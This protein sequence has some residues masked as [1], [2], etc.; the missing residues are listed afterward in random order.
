MPHEYVE[1]QIHAEPPLIEHLIGT[2]TQLGFEGFWEETGL[3]K[4]YMSAE[5]WDPT[6]ETAIRDI[7]RLFTRPSTEVPPGFSI[8]RIQ[9]E[10]WNA[11]WEQSITPI[12]LTPRIVVSPTWQE[13]TPASGEILIRINPKMS[14]GTGYHESTRLAMAMIENHL[15]PGMSVLDVGT[16]TGILAIGAIILGAGSATGIDIDEWSSTNAMENAALNGV[17]ERLTI[18]QC[19]IDAIPRAPFDMI[20]ANIQR[21]V[22]EQLLDEMRLRL[23]PSGLLVLSGLLDI[24][25]DPIIDR[26]T[27]SR[28][29]VLEEQSEH[30]WVACAAT[31]GHRETGT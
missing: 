1:I 18:A 4:C 15:A 21:S 24:D 26:L 25:R 7:L 8:A 3:L 27:A 16:G 17:S 23:R 19:E 14:F 5:R 2:L 30:E 20:V 10:N 29:T 31:L 9:E 28:F 6:L 22:I 12:H 13:Y 11:Q